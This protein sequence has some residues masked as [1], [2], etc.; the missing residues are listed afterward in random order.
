MCVL[1]DDLD[2]ETSR[3]K[4]QFCDRA[5]QLTDSRNWLQSEL[6]FL[7]ITASCLVFELKVHVLYRLNRHLLPATH[8]RCS[9]LS[10]CVHLV[11]SML[12][13]DLIVVFK[14]EKEEEQDDDEG[15]SHGHSDRRLFTRSCQFSELPFFI[16][17]LINCNLLD[18]KSFSIYNKSNIRK[19]F[20]FQFPHMRI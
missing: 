17:F 10:L 8:Y 19:R 13:R 3:A 16:I 4:I 7:T 2:E 9:F 11:I 6:F 12:N 14:E 15:H 5:F 20:Q 18:K 1:E